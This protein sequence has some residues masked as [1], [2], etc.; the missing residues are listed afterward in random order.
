[1]A[2]MRAAKAR[3]HAQAVADGW[4]PEPEMVRLPRF[5]FAI[6]EYGHGEAHWIPLKSARDLMRRV[7]VINKHFK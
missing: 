4:E 6:R 1:M 2:N 5:E 3:K 7:S